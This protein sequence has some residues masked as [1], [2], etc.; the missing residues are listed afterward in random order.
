MHMFVAH[1]TVEENWSTSMWDRKKEVSFSWSQIN[2]ID[3]S[4]LVFHYSLRFFLTDS[5]RIL[6]EHSK[7]TDRWEKKTWETVLILRLHFIFGI[8]YFHFVPIQVKSAHTCARIVSCF[9]WNRLINEQKW[10]IKSSRDLFIFS[11][12]Y[13]QCNTFHHHTE[14]FLCHLQKRKTV[15]VH[16]LI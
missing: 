7:Y 6:S 9:S 13:V 1:H 8:I 11:L 16:I 2:A 4:F 10:W 14:T 12:I 5:L 3:C 15:L